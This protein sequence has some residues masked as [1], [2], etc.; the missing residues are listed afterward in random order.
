M[1]T[2]VLPL[3]LGVVFLAAAI[4]PAALAD[5]PPSEEPSGEAAAADADDAPEQPIKEI[6]LFVEKWKWTPNEITVEQGTLVKVEALSYDASRR[7]DLKAFR[8]KVPLPEGQKVRFEFV[9]DKVGKFHWKCGRPCGN[10]CAK[11]WG[12]LIVK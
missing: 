4:A 11:L 12:T 8:L 1:K 7:F 9:A 10:G 5:D 6:K 3:I 2:P